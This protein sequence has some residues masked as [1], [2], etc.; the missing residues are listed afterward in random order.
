MA[1]NKVKVNNSLCAIMRPE[2]ALKAL[3]TRVGA[4]GDYVAS[5]N[6]GTNVNLFGTALTDRL[7]QRL[8]LPVFVTTNIPATSNTSP[9]LVLK[10]DE[11]V[12]GDRQQL[13]LASSNVAGSSFANDQTLIRA[14]MRVDFKLMRSQAL[15]IITGV[16]H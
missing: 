16:A 14:I 7:S 13:E 8:G 11:W 1:A 9:I 5:S 3:I 4:S 6:T 2:V 12:I 15:E 10:A